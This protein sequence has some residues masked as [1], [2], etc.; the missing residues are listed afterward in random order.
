M[1]Y[2]EPKFWCSISYYEMNSRI[3]ETFHASQSS[4]TVDGFVD[5]SNSDRFCLG[6]LSNVNRSQQVEMARRHI[7]TYNIPGIHY[8]IPARIY[9]RQG[10]L[11]F[12]HNS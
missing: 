3:G 5:P 2:T 6:I 9:S 10:M 12:S 11:W 1:A 4:L 8:F 7:G